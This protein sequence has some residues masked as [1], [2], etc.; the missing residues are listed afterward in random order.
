MILCDKIMLRRGSWFGENSSYFEGKSGKILEIFG[1]NFGNF[2]VVVR[3]CCAVHA[4]GAECVERHN[5]KR[6]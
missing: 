1:E 6:L 5:R 2:C 3:R 4:N